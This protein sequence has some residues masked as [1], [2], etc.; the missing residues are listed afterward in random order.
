MLG[1]QTIGIVLR[2]L[3]DVGLLIAFEARRGDDERPLEFDA[4][5][6]DRDRG[7]GHGEVDHDVG[8]GLADDAERHADFADAGDEAGIFA[9]QRVIGRL[10]RGDDLE[11]RVLRGEGRDALAHAAGGAVNGEFHWASSE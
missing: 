6:D 9:E 4:V 3:G 2:G 8:A 10:E 7:V 5:S 1:D 11:A